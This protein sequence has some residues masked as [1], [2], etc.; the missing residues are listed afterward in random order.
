MIVKHNFPLE[1]HVMNTLKIEH[2]IHD[3]KWHMA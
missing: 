3:S 1:Q 2:N